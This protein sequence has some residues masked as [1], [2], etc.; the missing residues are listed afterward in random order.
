ML[1]YH[2]TGIDAAKAIV[3]SRTF[4]TN[5]DGERPDRGLFMHE[6]AEDAR[7]SASDRG[8]VLVLHWPR[9]CVR[10]VKAAPD[11]GLLTPNEVHALGTVGYGATPAR[12]VL[13]YS[14][15]RTIWLTHVIADHVDPK[16]WFSSLWGNRAHN[17]ALFADVLGDGLEIT[18]M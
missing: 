11:W 18:L 4:A 7:R 3:R 10:H 13:P 17:L 1:L 5:R 6:T 9:D 16:S 12:Y 14:L 8:S 2:A 15:E